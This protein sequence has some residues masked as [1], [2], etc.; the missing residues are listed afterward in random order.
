MTSTATTEQLRLAYDSSNF[1]STN[2][3]STGQTTFEITGSAKYFRY[4]TGGASLPTIDSETIATFTKTTGASSNAQISIIS[5]T[6]GN[7]V[8]RFGDTASEGRGQIRYNNNTDGFELYTSAAVKAYL[9]STGNFG[10]GVSPTHRLD[11]Y[12]SSSSTG[13]SSIYGLRDIPSG[14]ISSGSSINGVQGQLT[15]SGSSTISTITATGGNFIAEHDGSS[16]V[17]ALIGLRGWARTNAASTGVL[18]SAYSFYAVA[19]ANSQA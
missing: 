11:S 8:I 4:T 14:T 18:A 19:P 2:V 9:S 10:V 12:L 13:V 5:G 15:V 3:A 17:H 7:A 6:T 1:F 16:T